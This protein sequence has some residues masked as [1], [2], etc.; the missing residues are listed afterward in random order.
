MKATL[1]FL[2]RLIIAILLS[3]LLIN[4]SGIAIQLSTVVIV[5]FTC[6]FGIS[7]VSYIECLMK[8]RD[9]THDD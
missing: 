8:K 3:F 4:L 2:V 1:F 5:L 7:S 6:I 9:D